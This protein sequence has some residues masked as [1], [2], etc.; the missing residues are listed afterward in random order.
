MAQTNKYVSMRRG[1]TTIELILSVGIIAVLFAISAP[2][3]RT[4]LLKNDLEVSFNVFNQDL[5]RAQSLARN[6]ERDSNWGVRIQPGSVTLFMGS[7]YATRNTA[8]DEVYTIPSSMAVIGTNE[9]VYQKFSGLPS[10]S[11]ATTIQYAGESHT[12]TVNSKGMVEQ[13]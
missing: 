11:G 6:G 9:Y 1:L 8:F 2:V 12:S 10:A 5:Y 4:F 7:S 13:Q 3:F